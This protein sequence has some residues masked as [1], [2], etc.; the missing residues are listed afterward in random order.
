MRAY[1]IRTENGKHYA[2]SKIDTGKLTNAMLFSSKAK[3]K[4]ESFLKSEGETV[5][6][7]NIELVK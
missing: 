4:K 2:T 1:V 6:A 5:V 3:A 7:V